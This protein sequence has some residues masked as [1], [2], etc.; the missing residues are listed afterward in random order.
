MR[1]K[2][3]AAAWDDRFDGAHF[4]TFPMDLIEPCILA[5]C[6]VGEYVLDP[7][8]GSGT[9][10]IVAALLG[11]NADLIELNPD[12]A[13]MAI[14][15]LKTVPVTQGRFR[16]DTIYGCRTCANRIGTLVIEVEAFVAL[17]VTDRVPDGRQPLTTR[18]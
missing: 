8:A 18:S 13:G 14:G 1:L 3:K 12:Y 4:A 10:G 17:A 5:G 11:R 9:T 15:R 7:F 2:R 6:P 16:P